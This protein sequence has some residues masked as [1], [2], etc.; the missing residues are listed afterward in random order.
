MSQT[1]YAISEAID[2]DSAEVSIYDEIGGWGVSAK[3][4]LSDI[5]KLSGKHLHL[6]INSPGGSV[7][8][9]T[10]IFN[11]LRRHKGGVTVHIDALAASMASVIA[12]SG[13]PV[14]IADNALLM[15][16]N[17]WTLAMGDA[18]EL[19]KTADILDKL[20]ASIRNAYTRK[21]GLEEDRVTELMD[22]ETWL[23][24]VDCVAL[25]FADA[26]EEGVPAAAKIT[27]AEIKARFDTWTKSMDNAPI[28]DSPVEDPVV[29]DPPA[30]ADPP[31][32]EPVVADP[33]AENPPAEPQAGADLIARVQALSVENSALLAEKSVFLAEI[34]NYK[35]LLASLEAIKGVAA[36]SVV[37]P[38]GAQS[39]PGETLL[40]QFN[41]ISDPAE[42]TRFFRQNEAELKRQIAATSKP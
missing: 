35:S 37:P 40:D 17:P 33:P 27:P 41:A 30:S 25:G 38:V 11:A 36:A 26:I 4:F 13:A 16:H 19:R 20:K 10:A 22:A 23:D 14:L 15:I 1:W 34:E 31:V 39:D 21:T 2:D 18:E 7:V 8:E 28:S 9:G 32:V 24:A 42:R 3:Q 29:T 5:S 12:M 6:R